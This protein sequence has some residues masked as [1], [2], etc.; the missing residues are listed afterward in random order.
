MPDRAAIEAL[1]A[2]Q[3]SDP[4]AVLGL[5]ACED[6]WELRVLL[7]SASAVQL[8]LPQDA[9]ANL[10]LRTPPDLPA[11]CGWF[12]GRWP[13]GLLGDARFDYRLRVQ[14]ANGSQGDYADAYAFGPQLAEDALWALAHGEHPHADQLLGGHPLTIDGVDG[15]RFAVWAPNARR[16]SVVGN[17]NDWDGRRHPMRLRHTAGVWELFVPHVQV[18]DFY[19]FE[20]L[21][22]QG[23]LLPLKAD[24]YAHA[25]ELRPGTAS[26]VAA[27]PLAQRLPADR[28]Q[29][30]A[31]HAAIS[32]YEA[33]VG[34]WRRWARGDAAMTA[35]STIG[36]GLLPNCPTTSPSSALRISS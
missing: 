31:R 19:K 26:R 13:M 34:S 10:P 3:H 20:L 17:F 33:H 24:P 11:G 4:F 9:S 35:V 23:H 18:G 12:V 6:A 7:P 27:R 32:I 21:D 14:W 8:I 25:S 1:L 36:I 5:H 30:N 15:V 16:V 29:A 28:G 2:G 22:A